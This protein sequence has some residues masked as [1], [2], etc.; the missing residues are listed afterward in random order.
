MGGTRRRHLAWVIEIGPNPIV[1]EPE[2][3]NQVV[4]LTSIV[5]EAIVP[6]F[7]NQRI[8]E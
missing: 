5:F 7:I 2:L 8:G 6:R 1:L 3:L 4:V